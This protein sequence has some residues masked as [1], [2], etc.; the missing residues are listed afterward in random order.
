[1]MLRTNLDKDELQRLILL[2]A[3]LLLVWE[4]L[5][6][7]LVL[8]VLVVL[9]VRVV[10]ALVLILPVLLMWYEV[11]VMT[12]AEKYPLIAVHATIYVHCSENTVNYTC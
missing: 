1:M 6:V 8:L 5:E 4:V 11:W 12:C 3:A 2:L 10:L 7:L 9:V